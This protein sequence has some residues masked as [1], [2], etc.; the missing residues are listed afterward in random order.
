MV[1]VPVHHLIYYIW[2]SRYYQMGCLKN[3]HIYQWY[4]QQLRVIV[5]VSHIVIVGIWYFISLDQ[6]YKGGLPHINFKPTH[7]ISDE[8]YNRCSLT[9]LAISHRPT[10]TTS[11][12]WVN[13]YKGNHYLIHNIFVQEFIKL[14]AYHHHLSSLGLVPNTYNV[15]VALLQNV[16]HGWVKTFASVIQERLLLF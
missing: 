13:S 11:N 10:W 6:H 8:K 9:P 2:V 3:I 5:N 1:E 16:L 7:H 12:A 14:E 15:I 4:T